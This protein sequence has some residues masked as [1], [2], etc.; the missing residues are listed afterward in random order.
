MSFK[1][2]VVG[3]FSE[4]EEEE[5]KKDEEETNEI[6][7]D[8]DD[9]EIEIDLKE[10]FEKIKKFS[11]NEYA[12]YI[13]LIPVLMIGL[14]IR[15]RNMTNVQ[16][17]YLMGLDPYYFYRLAQYILENGVY[18]KFLDTM[19]LVPVGVETPFRF[20]PF[21]LANWHKF[22]NVF[23]GQP[24]I[25]S[26][27]IYP[28]IFAVLGFLFFFL[29]VKEIWG[30]RV[31][32][33]STA[34]FAVVPGYLYRTMAG[35]ADHETLAMLLLFSSL[36]LFV[37]FRNEENLKK[38]FLFAGVS[39]FLAS[40]MA[41]TWTGVILLVVSVS[42]FVIIDILFNRINKK[43]FVGFLI[44]SIVFSP[45]VLLY[46]MLVN[47][48]STFYIMALGI[49]WFP[50]L[51]LLMHYLIIKKFKIKIKKVPSALVSTILAA[52]VSL[53]GGIM[54]L[55]PALFAGLV[56]RIF[57]PGGA[58]RVSRT[59]SE[60]IGGVNLW[61]TFS[62]VL[63][64]GILGA[65]YLLYSSFK[66][67]KKHLILL[68]IVTFISL[69]IL[70][71]PKISNQV[72][73]LAFVIP[74]GILV[75]MYVYS[76]YKRG[77]K[78][79]FITESK[80][81]YLL[82]LIIFLVA[83]YLSKTAARFVFVFAPFIALMAG[84]FLVSATKE[85]YIRKNLRLLSILV[86]IVI[87][88]IF[89][90]NASTSAS[91]AKN[92]G[93]HLPGQW[94][95]SMLW[96][97]DNT[98]VDSVVSHWWDYGYWTQAVAERPSTEDG[99]KGHS[100]WIY[101][102]ARYG[103]VAFEEDDPLTY[104]KSHNVSYLLYS[105]EE[106]GK[107]HAFSYLASHKGPPGAYDRESVIGTFL[108]SQEKEVRNGTLYVYQGGWTFDQDI[109]LDN[110]VLPENK[111]GIGAF[112]ITL[113]KNKTLIKAPEAAIVYNDKQFN[114][115]VNCVYI[116]GQKQIFDTNSSLDGCIVFIDLYLNQQEKVEQGAVLFLSNKVYPGLLARLYIL[117][118]EVEGFEE[119]YSDDVPFSIFRNRVIGPIKIWK[120][121]YPED[122][123]VD[124]SFLEI[125]EDFE[126]WYG[127]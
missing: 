83:S 124:Q 10:T 96:L 51:I 36:W 68:E 93:S 38:K 87:V 86:I 125:P 4:D 23:T 26:H 64:F 89:Y 120:I 19:R 67:S 43:Y 7:K 107:Y 16:G 41:L 106:I 84:Y 37:K 90:V 5:T 85:L 9:E 65:L 45:L 97:R 112:L 99:G 105:W 33:V 30:G 32:L 54:V 29:F 21:F 53:V 12:Y 77:D 46:L 102:L 18:L 14:W 76:Y 25:Y 81:A 1:D 95:S 3:L 92:T 34:I 60:I 94:E 88:G 108:L 63:I 72:R 71:V 110:L 66:E 91:Q 20:F 17:K 115:E 2:R 127:Y 50:V 13:L 113:D 57:S 24:Q 56:R 8:E 31:A 101:T 52:L 73:L 109:V 44:W 27:V 49:V 123:K 126:E 61:G 118:E 103:M 98:P 100:Y 111:A 78:S 47:F 122:V 114:E 119:V 80:I 117:N 74:T 79:K 75:I 55:G 35:F 104:F 15:L 58:E 59:T 39:G 121:S 40:L 70:L 28:P 11:L 6:K 42:L 48:I 69:Y 82:P 116:N 62:W 22:I